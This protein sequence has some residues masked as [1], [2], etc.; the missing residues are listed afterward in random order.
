MSANRF[1]I[2]SARAFLLKNIRLFKLSANGMINIFCKLNTRMKCVNIASGKKT[3]RAVELY[4]K[5][6]L[7][8]VINYFSW[9]DNNIFILSYLKMIYSDCLSDKYFFMVAC[10]QQEIYENV[11]SVRKTKS[12][13]IFIAL[14]RA[15]RFYAVNKYWCNCQEISSRL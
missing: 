4:A 7:K 13:R 6:W 3:P 12:E 15:S 8:A 14:K 11:L 9:N 5:T 1:D 2:S 10:T